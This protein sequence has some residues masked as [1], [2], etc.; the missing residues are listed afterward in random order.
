MENNNSMSDHPDTE[1]DTKDPL[2][3]DT[4]SATTPSALNES[5][6]PTP[7]DFYP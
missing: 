4:G 3:G 7:E 6:H 2:C 5:Q 1:V